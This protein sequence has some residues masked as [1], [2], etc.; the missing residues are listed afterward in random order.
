MSKVT[1][2]LFTAVVTVISAG[3]GSDGPPM[4]TVSGTVT[5]DSQ[6]LPNALV[7]FT[8][9][10]VN[11]APSYGRTDDDGDYE[12]QFSINR[13]GAYLGKHR[14]IIRPIDDEED[15]DGVPI[16]SD[17]VIPARYNSESELTTVVEAGSNTLDFD[18]AS[19]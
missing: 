5:L 18:L 19:N 9:M 11:G 13:E 17:V 10:D 6:P 14:V 8:P 1:G 3:C 7:Q 4:G 2:I 15:E 12:L 16:A